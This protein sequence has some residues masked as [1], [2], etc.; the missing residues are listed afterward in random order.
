LVAEGDGHNGAGAV[1]HQDVIGDPDRDALVGDRIDGI[2][3]G[4]DAGTGAGLIGRI[5]GST[6]LALGRVD[7]SS[8]GLDGLWARPAD[9]AK[10][11]LGWLD[12]TAG[13]LGNEAAER[14]RGRITR[15]PSL[16]GE[17]GVGFVHG[18]LVPAN[19]LVAGETLAALLDLETVRLGPRLLDAAWFRWIVRYH[20]PMLEPSAWAGFEASGD[21]PANDGTVGALLGILPVVRILEIVADPGL[22][23]AARARWLDHLRAAIEGLPA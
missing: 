23:P 10:A 16:L 21:L 5:L 9:L 22:A 7:P 12:V 6:W 18:D 11:A 3:T 13:A 19:V 14:A 20:H 2:T 1:A 4:E 8:L 17:R 15:L